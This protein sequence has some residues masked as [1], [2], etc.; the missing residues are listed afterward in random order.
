MKKICIIIPYN[1]PVPPIL[2]GAVETLVQFLVEENEKTP[3]FEFTVLATYDKKLTDIKISY[4][5]TRFIY[6]KR[7]KYLD[8]VW[9][10]I[11]R[12]IKK[13]FHVYIPFSARF[14]AI[15]KHLKKNAGEYDYVLFESGLT[16]M[17][18]LVA[19]VYPKEKI[20]N[21][22][23]WPGDGNER[24][25]NSF[26]YLISVSQFCANKWKSATNRQDDAI[27]IL[28]NCCNDEA[29]NK[30]LD[31]EGAD[32]LRK[33]L[34]IGYNDHVVTFVGRIIPGKG[35]KELLLALQRTK[36]DNIVLIVIGKANFGLNKTTSF[37]N[38]II[39]LIESSK[40]RVIKRG[41]VPNSELYKYYNISELAITPSIMEDPAP[42][43]NIEVMTSGTPVITTNRGGIREYVGDVALVIDIDDNFVN[44]L[45]CAIDELLVDSERRTEMIQRGLQTAG[46]YTRKHYLESFVSIIESIEIKE[47]SQ[48]VQEINS[49]RKI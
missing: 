40:V 20:L 17:L 16:Y 27:F 18:P 35:I 39:R 10:F 3:F 31:K 32:K 33:E 23:H 48:Y 9:E 4:E 25:D 42:V 5:H 28:K 29:F 1:Y 6:Y 45:A 44:K 46:N 14:V 11:Y 24:I 19:K 8:A 38:E 36:T 7:Y 22:I 12:A 34:N 49:E 13:V 43:A 21:H 37:E 41:F 26:A 15:L 2:G 47:N 30:K